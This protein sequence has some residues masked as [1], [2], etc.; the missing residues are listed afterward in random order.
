MDSHT[1]PLMYLVIHCIRESGWP[2]LRF[3]AF[4]QASLAQGEEHVFPSPVYGSSS[5]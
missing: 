5:S 1:W 4:L 2:L 3:L